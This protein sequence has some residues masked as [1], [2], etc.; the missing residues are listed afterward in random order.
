MIS[1]MIFS[2]GRGTRLGEFGKSTPK[3]LIEINNQCAIFHI[4]KRI[5]ES[6]I[7]HI[8]INLMHLG[9][10]VENY[11]KSLNFNLKIDYSYEKELLETGGGLKFASKYLK[12]SNH[13]ILHNVDLY[14]S[15]D[16]K[17]LL[18]TH[19]KDNHD[20]TLAIQD[21]ESSRKFLFSNNLQLKGWKNFKDNKTIFITD[22]EYQLERAFSGV[23][24]INSKTLLRI[25]DYSENI[26][27][28]KDFYLDS[29]SLD[30]RIF[31]HEVTNNFWFDL[32][33]IEKIKKA[34]NFLY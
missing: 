21:R 9:K 32:G 2:A 17:N 3:A 11:V 4:I 33:T 8:V 6:G 25:S 18:N 29:L 28:I 13:I 1:A 27:S 24:C 34:N 14:T 19:I 30:L 22:Q 5:E 10:E 15:I 26:F 31:G 20:V 7:K 23:H 12:N 16:L